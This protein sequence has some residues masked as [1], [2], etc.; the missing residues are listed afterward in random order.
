[1]QDSDKTKEQL[2]SELAEL[3]K[4]TETSSR[5]SDEKFAKAFHYSPDI[6]TIS[7]LKEG[8]YVEVNDAYLET[9]GYQRNEVLGKSSQ[10]LGI[11][12][13]PEDRDCMMEKVLAH[14][15]IHNFEMNFQTKSGEIRTFLFSAELIDING[16]PHLLTVSRDINERKQVEEALRLSEE[17][18]SKAF[19][20]CP[21]LM[22]IS[23]LED[24]LLIDVNDGFC[25]FLGYER[26]DILG[27]HSLEIGFWE[28]PVDRFFIRQIIM[29]EGSVHE[30]EVKFRKKNGEVRYGIFSGE[31]I[32]VNGERCL[33]SV[34]TDITDRREADESIKYLSFHD[35]LTGVYNRAFFE[36][37]LKRI[38]IRREHPVSLILGDVNGLK[39]I[40]E[41]MGSG[42]GD[43][44]LKT[45]AKLFESSCRQGDYVARWGGDEFIILLS[46]CDKA[47]AKKV[48]ERIKNTCTQSQEL[49][50]QVSVSLGAASK[51]KST[52]KMEELIKEAEDKMYRNKLFAST[53]ARSSFI[54]SLEKTLW[55]RSHETK[56]HCHRMQKM[57]QKIA[58][59]IG[60]SDSELDNLKLM[61]TLHDIGKIAIPNSILDKPGKLSSEEWE[62]IRKHPEIGYRIALSSPELT[63][64]AEGI[65]NHHERWDGKGYPRGNKGECI[66][67]ISRIIAIIDTYD[68]MINGR[69]YQKP[70]AKEDVLAEISR[71]AG[72]QFDPALAE[73]FVGMF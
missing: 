61:A 32:K 2:I 6:I 57:A 53:S 58:R 15:D 62:Y 48:L 42:E 33:L 3:R 14:E 35:K 64:I 54:N 60:L 71:C 45:V 19:N 67:L 34:I 50:I 12:L 21:L 66:P 55:T 40:N 46:G 36:E 29:E 51:K 10:E 20:A 70:F 16:I 13:V 69:P 27:R 49:P 56:E 41:A 28:S 38:D 7:T 8:R 68:V 9:T 30:R 26:Q 52:R 73:V 5:R 31:L 17:R 63:P 23:N 18:F 72:T 1:M 43:K 11:W 39:L 37:Q 4:Q 25:R 44:L 65:L 47:N 22:S 59:A 24:G